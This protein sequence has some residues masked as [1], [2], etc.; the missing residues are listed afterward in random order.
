MYYYIGILFFVALDQFTKLLA[1]KYLIPIDTLPLINEVLHLTYAENTGAAFSIL[2]GKQFFL[3]IVTFLAIGAM[4][5]VLHKLLK[6]PS[7]FWMKICFTLLISGGIGNLIDRFRLNYVVDFIDFRLINFAIF[8]VA[9]S[10]VSVGIV[11]LSYILIF[12]K[13]T[14]FK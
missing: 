5:Y 6:T 3:K 13:T 12:N 10:L 8:N 7:E 9:D 1:V 4:F 11:L 14:L 2:S